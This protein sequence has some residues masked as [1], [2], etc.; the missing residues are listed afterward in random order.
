MTSALSE[1]KQGLWRRTPSEIDWSENSRLYEINMSSGTAIDSENPRHIQR[2]G[3]MWVECLGQGE[4]CGGRH[5]E[6][7]GGS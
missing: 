5:S 3:R 4:A 1:V 2:I 6:E 7:E